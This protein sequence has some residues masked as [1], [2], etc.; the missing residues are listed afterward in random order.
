MSRWK[1]ARHQVQNGTKKWFVWTVMDCE[2]YS[3]TDFRTWREALDYAD[4]RA[5]TVE[6]VLPRAT[7]GGRVVVGKGLYSLHVDHRTHCTDVTLGG[8]DGVTVENRYLWDVAMYLAA[9]AKHW[10]AQHG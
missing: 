3:L 2:K 10:E 6:V 9:C 1:V 8:W 5:R 4:E 7:Y